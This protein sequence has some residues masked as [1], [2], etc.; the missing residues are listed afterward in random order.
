M[1]VEACGLDDMTISRKDQCLSFW[2]C[3]QLC[4]RGWEHLAAS[5]RTAHT[6]WDGECFWK[7]DRAAL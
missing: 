1:L 7:E 3:L 2:E 5:P 4:P 6:V